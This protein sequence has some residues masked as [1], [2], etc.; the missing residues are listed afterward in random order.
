[1]IR[2]LSDRTKKILSCILFVLL[3]AAAVFICSLIVENKAGRIKYFD[4]YHT[5]TPY[6]VLFMGT[7]HAYNSFLPHEI[8]EESGISSYNCAYANCSAA[9]DYYLLQDYVKQAHP[10]VV[11][12]E[13]Y[14]LNRYD[15]VRYSNNQKYRTGQIEQQHVQ[16][17]QIPLSL[18]KIRG[19]Q[20]IF[21]DYEYREDFFWPFIL[22]HTRWD[23]LSFEN[24]TYTELI[25]KGGRYLESY[26][27]GTFEPAGDDLKSS[28]DFVCFDYL[29]KTLEYCEENGI[30]VLCLFTPFVAEEEDQAV[31]NSLKEPLEK[32]SCCT[33]INLLNAGIVDFSTDLTADAKHLNYSGANRVSRW[34]ADYLREHYDLDDYSDNPHWIRQNRAYRNDRLGRAVK[35]RVMEAAMTL[36]EGI[37]CGAELTIY[38]RQLSETEPVLKIAGKSGIPIKLELRDDPAYDAL[39]TLY[40]RRGQ[41]KELRY[42][43]SAEENVYRR[44]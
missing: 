23:K 8:W 14:G 44:K 32:F 11:V 10:K 27:Y 37:D 31:A 30:Q 16:Y 38:S 40:D 3:T 17:D 41:K 7:S 1:M 34:T 15:P 24:L 12:L 35:V 19:V 25:S 18:N 36:L 26:G 9:E 20:D 4:F 2:N 13:T 21:D 29:L 22:Y 42:S 39:L 43:F 33:Y 5:K 6:D 28:L